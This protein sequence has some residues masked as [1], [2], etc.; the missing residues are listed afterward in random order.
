MTSTLVVVLNWNGLEDTL[1][2]LDSLYAQTQPTD[3]VVVDN[4]S[5]PD[6]VTELRELETEN[7][8]ALVTHEKNLGYTGGANAGFHYAIDH[9]YEYVALLNNDAVADPTWLAELY[10]SA[11][12]TGAGITTGLLLDQDGTHI[13]STAELYSI[14]GMPFPRSRGLP[15][16]QAP[17]SG[18]VFGAT[19][20]ATLFHVDLFEE[21]GIFEQTYFAYFEDIDL[22]FRA[23]QHQ[24]GVYYT[25]AAIARHN[26]GQTSKKIP[27]FNIQQ[28]FRNLPLLY[29]RNVPTKLLFP[30]GIRLACLYS[31]MFGKAIVHGNGWP[32]LKGWAASV[33]YFWTRSLW[34]RG[35]IQTTRTISANDIRALLY[36]DLPPDQAGMRKLRSFLTRKQDA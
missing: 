17:E 35:T 18:P 25:S 30:I 2:C 36:H 9:G 3:I 22:S 28:V 11:V 13:D 15:L 7:K 29:I 19:G 27:G 16:N 31:L 33:W 6:E 14:W 8:I 24:I 32:A 21:I 10:K 12:A 1:R 20:G 26:K 34:Q 23:Q 5:S 4:G